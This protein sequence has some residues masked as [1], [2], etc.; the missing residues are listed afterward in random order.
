VTITK[1]KPHSTRSDLSAI[2]DEKTTGRFPRALLFA[3]ADAILVTREPVS[4]GARG[5]W[6]VAV[7]VVMTGGIAAMTGQMRRH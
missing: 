7:V 6:T 1:A 4:V 5:R 2:K 3:A